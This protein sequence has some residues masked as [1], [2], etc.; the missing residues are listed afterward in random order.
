LHP[1]HLFRLRDGKAVRWEIFLEREQALKAV[2][3]RE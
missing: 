2:G 3:L 1:V